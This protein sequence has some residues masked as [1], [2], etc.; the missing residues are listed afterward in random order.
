MPAVD[1]L[2]IIFEHHLWATRTLIEHCQTLTPEQL[3]LSTPGTYGAIVPTITHIIAEDQRLLQRLTGERAEV[4]VTEDEDFT[5]EQLHSV[6][7]GQSERWRKVLA[8]RESLDVTLPARDPWPAVPGA[9]PLILLEAIQ[10]GNDHRTH[11]CS[12]LG[13][14]GLPI[15]FLCGWA[16][17][18]STGRVARAGEPAA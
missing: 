10:H 16:F 2:E 17:W 15:E 11:V 13:A 3:E 7:G 8:Q 9:R 6:W 5:L 14:H 18:R 4:P 1:D 12:V